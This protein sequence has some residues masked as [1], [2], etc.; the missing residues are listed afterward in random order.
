[1]VTVQREKGDGQD[2]G[3]ELEAKTTTCNINKL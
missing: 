3:R 2:W 1:M